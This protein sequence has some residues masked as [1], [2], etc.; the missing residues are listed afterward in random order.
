MQGITPRIKLDKRER[1][2][3]VYLVFKR[4]VGEYEPKNWIPIDVNED[5]VTALIDYK[6][7]IFETGQKKI[8][9]GYYYRRKRVQEK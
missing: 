8:T 3:I 2:L 6:P 5:N 7:I 9:L 4:D 1:R